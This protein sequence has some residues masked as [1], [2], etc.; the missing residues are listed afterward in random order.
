MCV[1]YTWIYILII[2]QQT[3]QYTFHMLFTVNSIKCYQCNTHDN[4]EC[5]NLHDYAPHKVSHF[6]QEC[7]GDHQGEAPFCRTTTY[8]CKW[9]LTK[10]NKYAI[11]YSYWDVSPHP[12]WSIKIHNHC[13][14]G[15]SAGIGVTTRYSFL[16]LQT[17]KN[18]VLFRWQWISFGNG[19]SVLRRWLQ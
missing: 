13:S 9:I 16:W 18:S 11:V 1:V 6:Y 17:I 10:M 15:P 4:P 14:Q 3:F 8:E 12:C 2:V 19:L 5:S 7:G